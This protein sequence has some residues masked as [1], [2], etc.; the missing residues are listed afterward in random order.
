MWQAH[1][2]S[3]CYI[4]LT[5]I[6]IWMLYPSPEGIFHDLPMEYFDILFLSSEFGS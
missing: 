5:N 3:C 1:G 6:F 2:L 4:M